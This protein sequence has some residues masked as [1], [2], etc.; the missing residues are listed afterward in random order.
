M[1]NNLR[2]LLV[3]F[4]AVVF[5]DVAAQNSQVLYYMNLPQNHLLNP[6]LRPSNTFYIGLPGVTGVNINVNNN[7]I[8]C[9]SDIFMHSE[10]GDSII[11]FLHPDYNVDDFLAK[12]KDKNS[13]EPEA[14]IQLFGLGFNAGKNLYMFIDIIERVQGNVVVPRDLIVLAM[15]GNEG[16]VGNNIDLTSL[17]GDLKYFREAG[18]GLSGN[19]TSRLRVGARG[20]LLFGLASVSIKNRSLGIR[21]NDDY[22]HTFNADLTVNLSGPVKVIPDED[23]SV[24]SIEIDDSGFDSDMEKLDYLLNTRNLGLGLDLG[25]EYTITDKIL[26]SASITDLGYIPWKSNV[27]NLIA[28]TSFMFR[29]FNLTDVIEGTK[30]FEEVSDEML[31]SL[32][33]S[34]KLAEGKNKFTTYLPV[35]FTIGGQYKLTKSFSVGLLSY[36][37]LIGKQLKESLSLSANLNLGNAFSTSISYT[38]A[39]QRYDNLGAGLSFRAGIFQLYVVGDKIPVRWNKIITGGNKI[40]LPETFNTLNLRAG[41][42]LT[43]GNRVKVKN[44]RP[45]VIVE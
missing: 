29:G 42:N 21:V 44:D 20:K 9:F 31:D 12:I 45:M 40:P 16:F 7:F 14:G 24:G 32:E 13:I 15:K 39:N 37:R 34:L 5:S 43:F 38:M 25:A 36:S 35:G 2:N 30:T 27:S 11:T 41:L 26:I 4:L 8:R 22:S 6:A 10:S 1:I 18:F 33:N 17:R 19:I 3:I 28:D 23:N